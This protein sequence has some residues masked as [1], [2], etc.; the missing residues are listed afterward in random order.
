MCYNLGQKNHSGCRCCK[1]LESRCES[2]R[3][4]VRVIRN[5]IQIIIIIIIFTCHD[6]GESR[7]TGIIIRV[8]KRRSN[9]KSENDTDG[10]GNKDG[11][12]AIIAGSPRTRESRV[13]D[14]RTRRKIECHWIPQFNYFSAGYFVVCPSSWLYTNA[15]I[16]IN[17]EITKL[18]QY[19]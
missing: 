10:Y 9:R 17:I 14:R 18:P 5:Q 16:Y 12:R 8:I 2:R 13:S 19:T 15:Y 1:I 6:A 7:I 4:R 3:E 11:R